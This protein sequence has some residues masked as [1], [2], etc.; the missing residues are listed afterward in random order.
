[1]PTAEIAPFS[2]AVLCLVEL[3]QVL[4]ALDDLDV[5]GLPKR[6]GIDRTGRPV[7]TALAVAIPHPSRFPGNLDFNGTA[8]TLSLVRRRHNS[9]HPSLVIFAA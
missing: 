5:F 8:K 9:P 7:P 6:E 1:M 4:H 2:V 3:A